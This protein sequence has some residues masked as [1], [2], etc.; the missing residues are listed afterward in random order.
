MENGTE[1]ERVCVRVW[2]GKIE[3]VL[4]IYLDQIGLDISIVIYFVASRQIIG[5]LSKEITVCGNI[6]LVISFPSN[7]ESVLLSFSSRL[8][9][10]LIQFHSPFPLF[11]KTDIQSYMLFVYYVSLLSHTLLSALQKKMDP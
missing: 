3:I 11:P 4:A 6:F 10:Q 8:V 5:V 2:I 1:R 7:I 9:P